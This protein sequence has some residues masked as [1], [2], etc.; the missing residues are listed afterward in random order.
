MLCC[1]IHIYTYKSEVGFGDSTVLK[2]AVCPA[3]C[4]PIEGD[5]ESP[6]CGEIQLMTKP[7]R[8]EGQMKGLCNNEY[9]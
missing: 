9:K 7:K 3:S 6:A 4:C 2:A 5:T 8:R 1:D